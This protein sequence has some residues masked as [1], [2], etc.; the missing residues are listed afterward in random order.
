M[1]FMIDHPLVRIEYRDVFTLEEDLHYQGNLD[2]FTVPA[3]TQTDF[4]SS[5]RIITWLVPT[6]GAYTKATILHDWF[7]EKLHCYYWTGL[8]QPPVNSRD[9]DGI[10]RR[11]MREEGVSFPLRW[12]MWAGI[13]W[14]SVWQAHRRKGVLKDMPLVLLISLLALPVVLPGVLGVSVGLLIYWLLSLLLPRS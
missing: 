13:R 7:C 4:A 3:G 8:D 12:L 9:A 6:M 14:G 1:T 2:L 5:P 11:I 10:F